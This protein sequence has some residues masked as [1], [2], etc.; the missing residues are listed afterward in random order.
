[1]VK[2]I[3]ISISQNECSF[4]SWYQSNMLPHAFLSAQ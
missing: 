4:S 3:L 1:M 2:Y